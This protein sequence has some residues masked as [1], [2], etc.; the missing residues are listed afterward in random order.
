ML[1]ILGALEKAL[2]IY[3]FKQA[4]PAATY[5][6]G[7]A[8][9]E[10]LAAEGVRLVICSRDQERVDKAVATLAKSHG[11]SVFGISADLTKTDDIARLV[12]YTNQSLAKVD[13]VLFNT[14]HPPTFPLLKTTDE[15]WQRGIDLVLT[16]AIK[17]TQAFLPQMLENNYGRLIYIV[18]IFG[19]QAEPSLII[20]STLRT[21]LNGFVKCV[22]S[23]GAGDGVT[24]NVICPGYFHTPLA[25][26]LAAKY[27]REANVST[28]MIN[29]SWRQ[30]APTKKFGKPEDLGAL[31]TFLASP[32]GEFIN[33]T[34]V[35]MDGG[36]VK[37]Y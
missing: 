14:G 1:W 19:L 8:C 24:A 35:T 33:G 32:R 30:L 26:D 23:E 7:Y 27:A 10:A 4:R 9:A 18:S 13:I 28:E 3:F 11:T 20:Q 22:A 29:D 36:L 31:V 12:E 2:L 37:Q 15:Q 25:V 17:L 34:A 21:G 5:G 16:P 6:L